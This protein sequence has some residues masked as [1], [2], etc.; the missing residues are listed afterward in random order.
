MLFVACRSNVGNQFIIDGRIDGAEEGEIICLSYPIKQGEVWKWQRD[1]TYIRGERFCFRGCTDDLRAASLTFSNMDYANLYLEPTKI[2]F[3]A[4]RNALYDYSLQGLSVDGELT[5][6]RN[7]FGE[8]ERELWEIHHLLQRK[9]VEWVT[10]ANSGAE[11]YEKL[12]AEFYALVAEHRAISS[13]WTSLAVEFVQAYPHYKI[14]PS[15]LEQLVAQGCDVASENKYNGT[16]GELL[17]LRQEIAKSCGGKVGTKAI[18]F[19]LDSAEGEKIRLSDKYANGYVLLDF[20]AS[21]CSPCIAEIPKLEALHDKCGDKL[22]ILSVSIDEDKGLWH[23][24]LLQHNITQ[25]TQLIMDRPTDA[26]SYYFMEQSDIAM[27]YGVTEIPCF[28]LV[29]SQGVI[30]GRW[31]HLTDDAIQEILTRITNRCNLDFSKSLER[32]LDYLHLGSVLRALYG[33]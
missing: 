26:D 19:V 11:N 1:T 31:S 32:V 3:E 30:V 28:I 22:Q 25:W 10:A 6:Y 12:M 29:D 2:T 4:K 33:G 23:K 9:N 21:W 8:L 24:A 14:T 13:H 17:S 5:E 27:A 15:I 7:T 18:D 20:W 16:M